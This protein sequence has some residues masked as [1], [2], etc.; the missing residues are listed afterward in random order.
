MSGI[1]VNT[2]KACSTIAAVAMEEE[3]KKR[4]GTKKSWIGRG[5]VDVRIFKR[6]R[7]QKE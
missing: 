5:I 6:L 3:K 1:K 4:R 2:W 7:Y